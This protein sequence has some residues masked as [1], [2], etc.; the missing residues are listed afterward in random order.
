MFSMRKFLSAHWPDE[1]QLVRF[2]AVYGVEPPKRMTARKWYDRESIPAVWFATL[3][4]LL[5]LDRGR[6]ISLLEFR[7]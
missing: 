4:M 1:R 2:V 6:P 3:V 7:Q 5:E